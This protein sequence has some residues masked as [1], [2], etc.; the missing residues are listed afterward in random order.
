[1]VVVGCCLLLVVLVI[2]CWLFVVV[3]G[4]YLLLVV[5]GW[6]VGHK[7]KPEGRNVSVSCW[8]IT[9]VSQRGG[10]MCQSVSCWFQVLGSQEVKGH[11]YQ[12]CIVTPV[13]PPDDRIEA[14]L[15]LPTKL[16]MKLSIVLPGWSIDG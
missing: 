10:G 8:L 3:G 16:P 11:I 2:C 14:S 13:V 1:M 7:G 9:K 6:L 4:G 15:V 12:E 5:V